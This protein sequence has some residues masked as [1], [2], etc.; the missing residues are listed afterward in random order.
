ML[1]EI[2]DK[3]DDLVDLTKSYCFTLP[4]FKS[5]EF[6]HHHFL[7]WS[8]NSIQVIFKNIGKWKPCL[9]LCSPMDYTVPGVL[10]ARILEWVAYPFSSGPSRPRNWTRVSWIAGRF[11]TS[12]ATGEAP[13]GKKEATEDITTQWKVQ[14]K[15][16]PQYQ[17]KSPY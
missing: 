9:T 6:F 4:Q 7:E 17:Y 8:W 3:T 16:N 1:Y 13:R 15:K 2:T 12:W 14:N 10:Q 5:K 11:F